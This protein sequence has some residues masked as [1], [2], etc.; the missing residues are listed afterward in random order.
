MFG[1][2]RD[3]SE[4]A[5]W[6]NR[7][8]DRTILSALKMYPDHAKEIF[9]AVP[10]MRGNLVQLGMILGAREIL[11]ASPSQL[12]FD[13]QDALEKELRA[14]LDELTDEQ[15]LLFEEFLAV[16]NQEEIARNWARKI[17]KE[18]TGTDPN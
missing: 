6:R 7:I 9:G 5:F 2:N 17:I 3:P 18:A 14:G 8:L 11:A 4:L 16:E 1:D 13:T 12:V 10:V 15:K